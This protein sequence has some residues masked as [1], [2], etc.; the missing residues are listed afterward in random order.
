MAYPA[1]PDVRIG[2]DNDGAVVAYGA[3]SNDSV[4]ARFAA[5][6]TSYITGSALIALNGYSYTAFPALIDLAV[7]AGSNIPYRAMWVFFPEQREVTEVFLGTLSTITVQ[8]TLV[9]SIQGSTDTTNGVDGTWQTATL[10]SPVGSGPQS[11]DS[12][13]AWFGSVSFTGPVSAIRIGLNWGIGNPS[14]VNHV[15]VAILHLYGTKG[16]GQTPDDIIYLDGQHAY[17]AFTTVEDFGNVPLGTTTVRTFKVQNSSATKTANSINLQ[18]NDADFAIST[19]SVTWVTTIN[20]ASLAAGASSAVL[21]V[22][23]TSPSPGG[24]LGPRFAR[25]VT[26]VGSWV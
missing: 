18:C 1:I 7:D 26:T 11:L 17:A 20:I 24:R 12:W 25:I 23:N 5:G 15:N 6:P 3:G 14:T 4:A 22:R 21:Y 16:A 9:S 2:Y 10:S 8:G 19:D 13:R